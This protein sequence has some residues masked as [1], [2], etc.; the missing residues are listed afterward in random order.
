MI[1]YQSPLIS[2]RLISTRKTYA[3]Q[4]LR[5]DQPNWDRA[6][7]SELASALARL[8]EW[9]TDPASLDHDAGEMPSLFVI[10][11]AE[12]FLRHLAG[13]GQFGYFP[14]PNM[15]GGIG[16]ERRRGDEFEDDGTLTYRQ[17]I[18]GK[19]RRQGIVARL[20]AISQVGKA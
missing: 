16:L 2:D 1:E 10:E 7:R 8:G 12:Q 18:G 20:W 17:L 15:R 9:R 6:T 13:A 5:S 3:V 11:A 14:S 19:L 4:P